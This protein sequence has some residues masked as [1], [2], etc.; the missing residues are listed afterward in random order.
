L[1]ETLVQD[2]LAISVLIV[3]IILA[4][5]EALDQLMEALFAVFARPRSVF[6][7]RYVLSPALKLSVVAVLVGTGQGVMFLA[8]GYV[9]VS[10]AG[11]VFYVP[12]MIR[13]MRL[14]GLLE[15]FHWRS[16]RMPVRE[17][18]GFSIPLLSTEFVLVSMSTA[19]VIILGFFSGPA[20]VAAFRAI[21]PAAM[22]NSFVMRSF[23]LLFLPLVSR[24]Y[25]RD[26]REAIREAYWRTAV[27]I[28][29]LTFP[30]FA[31]TFVF[32]EPM[33][34]TLFGERYRGSAPLL[35]ILAVGYY[36]NAALGFNSVVLQVVGRL[37]YLVV[38][39]TSSALANI[40][41]C[42]LL[43]PPLGALGVAIAGGFALVLQ[44]VLNQWGL[45]RGIGVGVFSRAHARVY[46]SIVTATAAL[47]LI[48]R[49]LSPEIILSVVLAGT[50]AAVVFA[51]NRRIFGIVD[52]YPGLASV[53]LL[54]RL[55]GAPS[56]V[57]AAPPA[58]SAIVMPH[59]A[60][61]TGDPE[62]RIDGG[63]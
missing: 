49:L 11:L 30:M 24:L 19:S 25:A 17:V 31:M 5:V 34:V 47:W 14:R 28:A 15:H 56:A 37:R 63:L 38:V 58:P 51:V 54:G 60:A 42:L 52:I 8:V 2:S 59:A 41:V 7:R 50:G 26:D 46:G 22:L 43:V 3:V 33:T 44:N 10:A 53:P 32:A 20:A 6:I 29:V 1:A 9:V 12:V 21:R 45:R 61:A 23:N 39:N 18:F 48:E 13:A 36:F 27:W 62:T 55:L 40:A 16:A 4:P 35:A 57:T